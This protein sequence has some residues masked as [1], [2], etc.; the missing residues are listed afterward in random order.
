MNFKWAFRIDKV[1]LYFLSKIFFFFMEY[2]INTFFYLIWTITSPVMETQRSKQKRMSS[3]HTTV[4]ANLLA[5]IYVYFV[6]SLNK[7]KE[8]IC[9]YL[10]FATSVIMPSTWI[11]WFLLL[12]SALSFTIIFLFLDRV[13]PGG[14]HMNIISSFKNSLLN[15]RPASPS[16]MLFCWGLWRQPVSGLL[17]CFLFLVHAKHTLFPITA[18]KLSSRWLPTIYV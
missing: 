2:K 17:F 7:K 9:F 4:S 10:N 12:L 3:F 8:C 16:T 15:P 6:V 11:F 5:S 1:L 18:L 13:I 14:I